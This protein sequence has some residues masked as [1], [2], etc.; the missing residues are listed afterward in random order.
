MEIVRDLELLLANP[1]L[2]QE[3]RK[4]ELDR[5]LQADPENVYALSR[6]AS[7]H[8]AGR[9]LTAALADYTR[10]VDLDSDW[11]WVRNGAASCITIAATTTRH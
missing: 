11:V 9:D 3:Q 6:R 10:A 2:T 8:W 5:A 7:A 4:D 1:E